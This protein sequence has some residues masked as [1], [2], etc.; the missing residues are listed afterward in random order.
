MKERI[1]LFVIAIITSGVLLSCGYAEVIDGDYSGQL[2]Q[3]EVRFSSNILMFT[4]YSSTDSTPSV[5]RIIGGKWEPGDAVG[6]YMFEKESYS[7]VGGAGNV[8][9]VTEYG[10]KTG[11]FISE[12]SKVYF[13][14]NGREVRFMSYYP[15]S[16][17]TSG[18]IYKVDVSNQVPQSDID[19]LYSFDVAA[20]Y[21]SNIEIRRVPMDFERQLTKIYINVRNGDGLQSS[22]L[23]KM[24]V[25][26]TGL[27][28]KADFNLLTGKLSRLTGL[29]PIYPSVIIAG[30]GNIY[31]G[32]AIV[33]P[34]SSASNAKIVIDL[35]NGK[36]V[37]TWNLDGV[38][39]KGKQYTYDVTVTRSGISVNSKIQ[40]WHVVSQETSV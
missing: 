26:I 29:S 18:I 25:Y 2:N 24:K 3:K 30:G 38:F 13:P 4:A 23:T 34:T 19:L 15:Y 20:T 22:D 32:E 16:E 6:I 5:S 35:N 21:D 33:I 12:N 14:V 31:S 10:G 1:L 28:T 37:Y 8:K 36:G 11:N 9:Y 40:N 7:V 17:Y 39:Y 27:S